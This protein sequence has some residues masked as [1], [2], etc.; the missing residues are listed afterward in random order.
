MKVIFQEDVKGKGKKGEL[1]E[2]PDGYARNFL[3]PKKLAVVATADNI[4]AMKLKEAAK[5]KQMAEEK[6]AA[7]AVAEKLKSIVV[8]IYAKAGTG[9]KLFGSITTKEISDGLR[10]QFEI[11]IEKNKIVQPEPIKGFGTF[12][13]KCKLGHEVGGVINVVV[14]EEK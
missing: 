3:L 2:V 8:K 9:G 7:E 6:A 14:A 4:N 5:K 10:T 1:K 13:I 11:N 12:E